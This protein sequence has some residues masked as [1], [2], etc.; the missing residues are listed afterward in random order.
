MGRGRIARSGT[1]DAEGETEDH[2]GLTLLGVDIGTTHVK[3]CAYDEAGRFLGASHRNTP[4]RRLRGG[5]AEYEA[6]AVERAVF[7]VIRRVAERFEPPRA[8]GVSSMAESGF[9]GGRSGEPLAPAVAW[10]DGRTAPQAA[11]WKERLDPFELFTRTGLHL[12]PRSSACKLEWYRE[13]TP[14]AWSELVPGS[15]WPSTWSSV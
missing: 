12:S 6:R 7:E 8:I 3:A 1:S 14:D 10:F 5:G 15:A 9:L 11:R 13:N 4:T 2:R